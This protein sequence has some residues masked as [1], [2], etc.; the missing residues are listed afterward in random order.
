MYTLVP[1]GNKN[2][3]NVVNLMV[4]SVNFVETQTMKYYCPIQTS[5]K[6]ISPREIHN[7]SLVYE[8][9]ADVG[10]YL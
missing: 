5:I 10:Y 4:N 9:Y 8:Q 6:H 7:P 3:D 2:L 1:F